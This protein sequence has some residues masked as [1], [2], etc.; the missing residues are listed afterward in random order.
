M[1]L[2]IFLGPLSAAWIAAE[3]LWFY[4]LFLNEIAKGFHHIQYIAV[5]TP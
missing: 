5:G 1:A 3:A 2:S 4:S